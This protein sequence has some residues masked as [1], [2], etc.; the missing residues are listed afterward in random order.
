MQQIHQFPNNL[1]HRNMP[2]HQRYCCM[3]HWLYSCEFDHCRLIRH[4]HRCQRR[5]QQCHYHRIQCHRHI[6]KHRQYQYKK[7]S[8]HNRECDQYHSLH[9]TH[10]CF[11]SSTISTVTSVTS[12]VEGSYSIGTS[13]IGRTVI[14]T[15][16]TIGDTS[17][18][19]S[20]A[21]DI[22]FIRVFAISTISIVA[23]IAVTFP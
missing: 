5:N 12:T 7:Q 20:G 13:C 15:P 8:R 17:D 22:T 21:I 2:K 9:R 10:Q 11:T 19:A 6:P 14:D 3:M 23:I 18:N 1:R 16:K 4:I